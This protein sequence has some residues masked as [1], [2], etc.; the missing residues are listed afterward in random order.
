[1][2]LNRLVVTCYADVQ[3]KGILMTQKACFVT[4]R[5]DLRKI[6][7][8]L[9]IVLGVPGNGCLSLFFKKF[10]PGN[11]KMGLAALRYELRFGRWCFD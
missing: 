5:E 8:F 4:F 7:L 11:M 6:K 10:V 2:H 3:I 1:M 9:C